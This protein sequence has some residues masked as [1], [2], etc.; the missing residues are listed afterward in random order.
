MFLIITPLK[1]RSLEQARP[2][3][4]FAPVITTTVST[5]YTLDRGVETTCV[6]NSHLYTSLWHLIAGALLGRPA[7]CVT[8]SDAS[9]GKSVTNCALTAAS[10]HIS[11]RYNA[12]GRLSDSRR[13]TGSYL[14]ADASEPQPRPT[15][16]ATPQ[17]APRTLW[18]TTPPTS[19]DP[20]LCV[21]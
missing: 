18:R 15:C 4:L 16:E 10:G 21:S 14:H 19:P 8:C 6:R 2:T 9:P 11:E 13:V 17:A 20:G 12:H 3:C 1:Y 7:V 5:K